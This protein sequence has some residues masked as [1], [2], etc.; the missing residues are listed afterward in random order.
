MP[1]TPATFDA[2]GNKITEASKRQ[3]T[4]AAEI[5]DN[6]ESVP[7]FKDEIQY[8]NRVNNL[9]SRLQGGQGTGTTQPAPQ[10]QPQSQPFA[11]TPMG[12]ESVFFPKRQPQ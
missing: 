3:T 12:L 2:K 10:A 5:L 11:V 6:P 1:M 8:F 9:K 4:K 7:M